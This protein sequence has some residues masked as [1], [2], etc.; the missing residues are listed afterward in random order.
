MSR[1][2]TSM[3]KIDSRYLCQV[4]RR[5]ILGRV[6]KFQS[7]W[8]TYRLDH[9]SLSDMCVGKVASLFSIHEIYLTVRPI[10]LFGF[11]Q[12]RW[13]PGRPGMDIADLQDLC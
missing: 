6:E 7:H 10:F 1:M 12:L 2:K 11:F 4:P 5:W 3:N 9:H 13:T 8:N